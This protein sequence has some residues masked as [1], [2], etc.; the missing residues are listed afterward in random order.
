[1][2]EIPPEKTCPTC[3]WRM[4]KSLSSD[5]W[6]HD[7]GQRDCPSPTCEICSKRFSDLNARARGAHLD[8]CIKRNE[9]LSVFDRDIISPHRFGYFMYNGHAYH[10]TFIADKDGAPEPVVIRDDR[11]VIREAFFNEQGLKF[12]EYPPS[13]SCSIFGWDR[14]AIKAWCQGIKAPS[15]AELFNRVKAYL[16]PRVKE[17]ETALEVDALHCMYTFVWI[18]FDAQPRDVA[19]SGPNTG[20]SQRIR[21]KRNLSFKPIQSSDITK[22]SLTRL[23]STTAGTFFV[24]NV[25]ALSED[26]KTELNHF[27]ESSYQSDNNFYRVDDSGKKKVVSEYNVSCPASVATTDTSWISTATRSRSVFRI[28]E[29]CNEKEKI[30]EVPDA[31]PDEDSNSIRA[32]LYAWG[33]ENV[34]RLKEVATKYAADAFSARD[35]QIAK[36]YLLL[37]HDID[38]ALEKRVTLFLKKNFDTYHQEDETSQRFEVSKA[39][40]IQVQDK[41]KSLGKDAT[42][43]VAVRA[44]AARVLVERGESQYFNIEKGLLN[45]KWG[46]LLIAQGR[47]VSSVLE[48][49]P[50]AEKSRDNAGTNFSFK[51]MALRRYFARFRLLPNEE[52]QESLIEDDCVD[53]ADSVD[54]DGAL[55]AQSR[56]SDGEPSAQ[57][58]PS[59]PSTS[60]TLST[61]KEKKE[62]SSIE[63]VLPC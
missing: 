59:P 19:G 21:A 41:V 11:K 51:R 25:D 58:P 50:S 12:R 29:R 40:Y 15:S 14:K 48:T 45:N 20:K 36:P 42:I 3:G 60:S 30:I 4:E 18:A 44:V 62:S 49:I 7:T 43:K 57:P 26:V 5:N 47:V 54:V 6:I 17:G 37:A 8:V 10:G 24:D 13:S 16:K 56:K 28:M 34:V 1:M 39:L 31:R 27:L 22:A 35:I 53:S 33:L 38:I 9:E 2:A 46:G 23:A 52:L 55:I 63:E 32:D 61:L